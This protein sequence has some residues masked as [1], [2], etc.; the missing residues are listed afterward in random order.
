MQIEAIPFGHEATQI[1]EEH[2]IEIVHFENQRV[3]F[4]EWS[5]V[6]VVSN[7]N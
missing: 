3:P 6:S 7:R 1:A 2:I 4:S 5:T